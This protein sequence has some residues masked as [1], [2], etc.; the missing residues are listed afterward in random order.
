MRSPI[1][2]ARLFLILISAF[3]LQAG[4]AIAQSPASGTETAA[5]PAAPS[6]PGVSAVKGSIA[7]S[8][9][10]WLGQFQS[11]R[12]G[13]IAG[14]KDLSRTLT[15]HTD[16]IAFGLGV[17]TLTLA[18]IRF[19]A[20]ADPVSAW[21][22]FFEGILVLGIF[23]SL[24]TGYDK[25]GPGVYEYFQFLADKIAGTRAMDPSFTLAAVGGGF[26]DAFLAS[27]SAASGIVDVLKIVIAGI[28]LGLA[29]FFC[30]LA[31]LLYTFFIALG[32]ISASIGIVIG[33]LAVALGL[34]DF[35]RRFFFSW[36]DFMI[37]ASMYTVVATIMA[38][39]VSTA[40]VSTLVHQKDV[41]QATLA[42]ASYAVSVSIFMLLV[43][44]EL[45]K[46]AGAIFGSGG[47]I[48]GGGVARAG[49]KAAGGVGKFLAKK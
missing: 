24:Y 46:I 44:F 45:P 41:G 8:I 27:M 15:P 22:D 47:G 20:T 28:P 37:G 43:A 1:W 9:Q 23:A 25:F 17:I 31:S 11:F 48:S 4:S 33:P 5:T 13:L 38:R 26:I 6:I 10:S 18:G 42:G 35:S 39:L 2:I 16:K 34:S 21:T 49:L 19:A 29:F 36:L 30:L 12:V 14:A 32:E 7:E 3:A 40:L